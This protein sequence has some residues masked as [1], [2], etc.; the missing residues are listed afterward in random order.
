MQVT[1][2]IRHAFL[3]AVM[4]LDE[5]WIT[6]TVTHGNDAKCPKVING[7]WTRCS[8]HEQKKPQSVARINIAAYTR[9]AFEAKE[10]DELMAWLTLY[11]KVAFGRK[12]LEL[13]GGVDPSGSD[14]TLESDL[15]EDRG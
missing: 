14:R 6:S 15:A 7:E 9:I 8:G 10:T 12:L 1:N 11:E 3:F 13:T 2:E 5:Q 4:H